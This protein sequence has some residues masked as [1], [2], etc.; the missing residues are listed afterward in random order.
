MARAT[1]SSS[2]S[3]WMTAPAIAS[4]ARSPTIALVDLVQDAQALGGAR[5]RARVPARSV[6]WA[7]ASLRVEPAVLE[8]HA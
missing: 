5:E 1:P 4:V 3:G 7:L 2:R 6:R 8:Q